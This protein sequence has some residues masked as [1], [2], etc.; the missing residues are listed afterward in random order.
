[1]NNTATGSALEV[2]E[3]AIGELVSAVLTT[4]AWS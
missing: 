4:A 2:Q 3:D 1:M